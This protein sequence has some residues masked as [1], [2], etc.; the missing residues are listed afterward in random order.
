MELSDFQA[1]VGRLMVGIEHPRA[2]AALALAEECGEVVRCV[3]EREYYGSEDEGDASL[4]GEVGDLLLALAELCDR[5]DLSLE[6]SAEVAL[7]KLRTKAPEWRA[8]L[9]DRLRDLRARHDAT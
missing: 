8:Q 5:Y 3:L 7:E 9:G 6:R 2:A 1:E 4:A